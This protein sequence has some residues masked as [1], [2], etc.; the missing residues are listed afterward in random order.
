[1]ATIYIDNE[2]RQ[3]N[4]KQNL[5]H[6][7]LSLG[8]DLPYFCWH[9]ALG[10][11]G[12]C[13]QCAVKQFRNEQDTT[14]KLV[15]ACMT[16]AA[17]GT[18]I[19][20]TDPETVIFRAAVIQGLMQSH[21]HDCPVCDEGGE[22]H[23]QDM[24]VMTGHRSRTYSF[25]KR[26]FR[27][28]YLGP[29]VNHEMNRCIQCQRCVRFYRE[30]AGGSD[31]N[32]FHLRDSIYFGRHEDGVLE[33]EFSG[34]LVEV[35]PTGVFTD[36]TLKHHYARKWDL[37]MAPSICVHCG[38]GCNTTLGERYGSLRRV[39]N[40]YNHQVNGYFLCDR[41]RFGYEFVESNL[42]VRYPLLN[43]KAATKGE[44]LKRFGALLREGNVL[45]IGSPRASLEGNFA[46]RTLV[47]PDR[48][49]GGISD[50][51]LRLLSTM[52]RILREGPARSPSLDEVE[53]SDA[54]F[55]LGEDVTNVAPIMALRLR[56]SMRQAPMEIAA[57]LHIPEWLDQPVR[58]AVQE[59]KGPMYI[60]SPYA[61]K[62]DDIATATY[63]AAP[64]DLAR[65][66]FAVAHAIDAS[67]PE[68]TGLSPELEKMAADIA[69]ALLGSK[70]PLLVSGASCRSQSVIEAAAQVAWAL[71]KA[72]HPAALSFTT[73]ECNSFGLAL[74]EP[75]PL[76]EAFRAIESEP[77]STLIVLE[78][79]LFRRAP[80]SVV[81]SLLRGVRHLVVLDHLENATTGAA[82][83]VLPAGTFAESDGTLVNNEGRA[84][85]SFQVVAPSTDIQE[86]WR[87]LCE[88]SM[89]ADVASAEPPWKSLDDLTTAMAADLTVFAS[90]PQVA[91][92]QKAVGKIA[93]EP[94]R[95][96]GRT[97]M[98]ANISVHE[99]KPPDDPDSALAFSM[100]SDPGLPPP[101]LN[102][103]FWAPGW[104][105]IQAVNKFQSE[106][107]GPLGGGD[108]GIRVLE[109]SAAQ[110]WQYYSTVPEAFKP[111]QD[112]WLFVPIFHIFGSEELSRHAQGISQLVPHPYL[113]LNPVDGLL[114]GVKADE[115]V[116]VTVEDSQFE[117]EVVLRADLPRGVA[118][119]PAGLP[120]IEGIP[121]PAFGKLALSGTA[122][123]ARGAA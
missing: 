42:R 73:P 88:G 25:G 33:N 9:P 61:T 102:P 59:A 24:T 64:E 60:V 123:S 94:N 19:S 6:A 30:Y 103:F 57:K 100:E 53:H 74:M 31:L 17:D 8:Y 63:H 122:L 105:S 98:L 41:G 115:Q 81:A 38:L 87:W 113:A 79:D 49:F 118:G 43:G 83:L 86:S 95:Y 119:L 14:G 70:N 117:L 77:A 85:R 112:G 7:C 13:R 116:K 4:P 114:L 72:G 89:A 120:M 35:C 39:V 67:A 32:A 56:Q 18:R 69:S 101:S 121:L 107:G 1:M 52:L 58:E 82:E 90:V 108:P 68:V 92:S 54:V 40:R 10:S 84:Q 11:V 55:V 12:A 111:Q 2:A 26:T 29:L 109:P 80:A 36:A 78:N 106:I 91:P 76:S 99:P 110:T 75:R 66:G 97:A 3:A 20:I 48:F 28:Q 96:S 21:P 22:C 62:L 45:G 47:S 44:T 50:Q 15:M 71:C 65:L 93:R 46:L 16:P 51:E 27:N 104:N 23:L 37:Q 5:L 34:N